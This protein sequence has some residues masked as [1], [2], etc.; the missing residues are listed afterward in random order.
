MRIR[1]G[2]FSGPA[3]YRRQLATGTDARFREDFAEVP[4]DRTRTDE[5]LRADF[6]VRATFGRESSDL[7]LLHGEF[8][9]TLDRA[10]ANRF[11]CRRQLMARAPRTTR[12]PSRRTGRRPRV[13][14]RL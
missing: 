7:R 1:G 10:A 14:A 3:Q 13:A 12:R 6:R 2:P 9:A 8:V 5:Q 4:L 11:A